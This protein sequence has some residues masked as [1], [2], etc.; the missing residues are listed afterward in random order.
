MCGICGILDLIGDCDPV[1]IEKMTARLTH[2]G[3]DC[4]A[5]IHVDG[6]W[7][8]HTRLSIIDLTTGAQPMSDATGRWWIVFN[9]EIYNYRELRSLLEQKGCRFQTS[10]DTEVILQS[11]I[12]FQDDLLVHLNGQ[13]AFAIWDNQEQILFA[14]RDRMG[15]KP[16]YFAIPEK[17]Q[18]IFA[19]EIKS[20]RASG[21]V[22]T[23]LDRLSLDDYLALLYVPPHKTIY[24]NVYTLPPGHIL[25]WRNGTVINYCYWKPVFNTDK[26]VILDE[27][28]IVTEV[29]RLLA[30]AVNR[31]MVSD[32]PIGAFLS[33]GLDS[34]TIVAIMAQ[35]SSQ[36]I[37]TFSA[38]FGFAIN[39]LPYARSVA[40]LYATDHHEVQIEV[41]VAE[42][43]GNM[44]EIYDEP[45]ADSSN[46]PTYLIS[47]FA[48]Q[49][50]KVVLSGDGGDEVFG[51][52]K[53]YETCYKEQLSGGWLDHLYTRTYD[54]DIY[55]RNALRRT[56]FPLKTRKALWQDSLTPSEQFYKEHFPDSNVHGLNTVFYYDFKYY[57]PGD[58]LV[59]VDRA[60]M[61][62]GLETR[63]PFLDY[64]LVE[65][66][67]SLPTSLRLKDGQLKYL[68]R[69]SFDD[70][71]PDDVRVRSKKG[72]GA[73]ID[74]WLADSNVEQ[75]HQNVYRK[76]SAL[77]NILPGVTEFTPNATA[78]QNWA[79]LC[80]G[81]W[82]EKNA[83]SL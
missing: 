49:Y 45:F 75:I 10:S 25:K 40:T 34:S 31:Q 76:G 70:L 19:S 43:L 42:L 7:L 57:L 30:Q 32:V 59:K 27:I 2:R 14:A 46:I 61:A 63:V 26:K 56:Y 47:K 28:E 24:E 54:R 44:T 83:D 6:A 67:L 73:P 37:K 36:P 3:P 55:K 33:G 9:G 77:V 39:E 18:F 4:Q 13:F 72:F 51:G 58:I 60:A 53:W 38:G 79:L 35:F 23:I 15:E 81:L 8:G 11:Y 74:I 22:H 48:R 5:S 82:L 41:P 20:I 66:L 69:R 1:V 12:F 16:F 65:F 80:L 62:N 29:R 21:L 64:E 78:Q 71:W 68:L 17:G 50:V 52:Y